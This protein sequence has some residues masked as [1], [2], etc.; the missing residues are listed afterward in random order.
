MLREQ[1]HAPLK[2]GLSRRLCPPAGGV[3]CFLVVSVA[4]PALLP[5]QIASS[6]FLFLL[7]HAAIPVIPSTLRNSYSLLFGFF[8]VLLGR[9]VASMVSP[10]Q[11][12]SPFHVPLEAAIWEI[13]LCREDEFGTGL[14]EG[15]ARW[16]A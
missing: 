1:P 6:S 12:L 11:H 8:H 14:Q 15:F 9:T 10:M 13:L 16:H 3:F 5:R 4:L 2:A 7:S